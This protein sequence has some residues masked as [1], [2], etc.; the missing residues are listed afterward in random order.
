MRL[1]MLHVNKIKNYYCTYG[2][3]GK[4]DALLGE[5][6]AGT[7][8]QSVSKWQG[9]ETAVAY[10]GLGLQTDSRVPQPTLGVILEWAG[11]VLFH[12]GRCSQVG[13]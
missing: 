8:S 11:K 6:L 12:A 13:K 10:R 2:N 5:S 1:C 3:H 9:E 7:S 4:V